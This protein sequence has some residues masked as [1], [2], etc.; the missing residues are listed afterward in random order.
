MGKLT[1]RFP[2]CDRCHQLWVIV[3][4]AAFHGPIWAG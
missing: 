1:A 4:W 2:S 3:Q